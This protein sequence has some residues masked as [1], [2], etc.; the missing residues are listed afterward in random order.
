MKTKQVVRLVTRKRT[1]WSLR[2]ANRRLMFEITQ[3]D[4]DTA[5][6]LNKNDCVIAKALQAV[7][8]GLERVEVGA[9]ITLIFSN[10][11]AWRYVTPTKLRDGLVAFDSTG[12]WNL[13]LGVY[14]L[15]P[16]PPAERLE[17]IRKR[18]QT[19]PKA[20]Q[21]DRSGKPYLATGRNTPRRINPR[22]M[23]FLETNRI[24]S[25]KRIGHQRLV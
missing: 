23:A 16:P 24:E 15:L 18:V 4:C 1:T 22:Y 11:A 13:P 20:R 9:T 25:V 8:P 10:N 14:A 5:C 19:L 21:S 2:D 7:V 17:A 3:D 6:R 12:V